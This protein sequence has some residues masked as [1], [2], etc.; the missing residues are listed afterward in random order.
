MVQGRLIK[1]RRPIAKHSEQLQ[2]S[3][4]N[5]KIENELNNKL[6]SLV[7]SLEKLQKLERSDF[8]YNLDYKEQINSILRS[9]I[10]RIYQ[11]TGRYVGEFTKREYY[12]T[13]TD[14]DNI[15][16]L[17][18]FYS[19]LFFSRLSRNIIS[20]YQTEQKPINPSLIVKFTTARLTQETMRQAIIA[21][22]QQIIN[23]VTLTTAATTEDIDILDTL[24]NPV[25]YVWT[26]SHD[27]SV[28]PICSG[29]E[30]QAWAFEDSNSIPDIPDDTHP[31][32]RCMLQLAEAEFQ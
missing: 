14:L 24:T 10:E 7:T 17:S 11:N 26:T 23:K 15:Q 32:C 22:S 30:G 20:D 3:K 6:S 19:N 21:K 5:Q 13:R 31:N 1:L 8:L 28:C 18:E 27:D 16:K 25:V 9:G 2:I 12:T 4:D 29:Y